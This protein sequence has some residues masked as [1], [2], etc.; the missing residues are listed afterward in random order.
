MLGAPRRR[1]QD[2]WK[3]HI[4]QAGV[5]LGWEIEHYNARGMPVGMVVNRC[6][7]ADLLLWARTHGH[8]P[9]GDAHRMLRLIESRG[10]VTAG[11]HL[12]LYWGIPAREIRLRTLAWSTCQYMF[13]ADGGNQK[14]FAALNI[15][16]HWCP[17]PISRE[18]FGKSEATSKY[19]FPYVFVGS[20]IKNIHGPHRTAL[21]TWARKRYK[22]KFHHYGI[23]SSKVYGDELN[24][25]YASAKAV[26][27]DSAP[28]PYYWSD[29]VPRTLGRGGLL[30]YPNTPGLA[31]QG[32]DDETLVTFDRFDFATLGEKLDS[33]TD[34]KRKEMTDAALTLI[35]ERHMWE[36]RLQMMQR[37]IFG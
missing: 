33:I 26:L 27:G 7:D 30:A 2:C 32:F 19:P 12:D 18:F 23:G 31:E 16:H 25:L 29:R 6:R 35:E 14:R 10:T 15:N 21:L 3:D 24:K 4:A 22:S 8:E 1:E 34:V 37:V 28:A 5:A 20:N 9:Q 11:I 36:H 17:P 13:T